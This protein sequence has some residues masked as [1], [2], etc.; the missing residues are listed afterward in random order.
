MRS[1]GH[2]MNFKFDVLKATRHPRVYTCVAFISR[3]VTDL[4]QFASKTMILLTTL[5]QHQFFF[6]LFNWAAMFSLGIVG[7][8]PKWVSYLG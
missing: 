3:N 7:Y 4:T 6:T 2:V 8:F 1:K 5:Q